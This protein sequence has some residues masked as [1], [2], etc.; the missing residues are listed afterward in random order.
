MIVKPDYKYLQKLLHKYQ[1]LCLSNDLIF[2]ISYQYSH[3][4][5]INTYIFSF[6]V[7][8]ITTSERMMIY[9]EM[10]SGEHADMLV[11]I[12]SELSKLN[13]SKAW[14]L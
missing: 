8:T 13:V 7:M 9:L 12:L 14:S 11:S 4:H 10:L 1:I 2:L 5:N 3:Y 6:F